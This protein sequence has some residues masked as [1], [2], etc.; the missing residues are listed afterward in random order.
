MDEIIAWGARED[1]RW[2]LIFCT[3]IDHA[4]HIRDRLRERGVTAETV[5]GKTPLA[6]RDR[7]LEEYRAGHIRAITNVG[8]MTTGMDIPSIDLIAFLRPTMSPS[9]YAQMA[10]RGLRLKDHTDYCR[11]LDFAGL[12]AMHGPITEII[13]PRKKGEGEGIAPAKLCP[14]CDEMLH[15]SVMVCPEC[16]HEFPPME[17]EALALRDDD[18]MGIDKTKRLEVTSW[19]WD[20]Q[21]SRKTEKE[22]IVVT[23]YGAMNEQPIREYLCIW[24]EGY[25]GRKGNRMMAIIA[26]EA[27]LPRERW[28]DSVPGFLLQANARPAPSAVIYVMEGRYPRVVE[29]EWLREEEEVPF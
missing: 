25:A 2:W 29:R 19:N 15:T 3:G 4:E 8:V 6:E 22:M 13:P 28:A 26:A 12:V 14:N 21:T 5:T 20:I 24:H 27:G 11:V 23:Y 9:L 7:I 16:G 10:G 1:R 17:R 18:I